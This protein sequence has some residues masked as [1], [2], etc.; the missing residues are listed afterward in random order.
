MISSTGCP[1]ECDSGTILADLFFNIVKIVDPNIPVDTEFAINSIIENAGDVCREIAG[2]SDKKTNILYRETENDPWE[3]AGFDDGSGTIIYDIIVGTKALEPGSTDATEEKYRFSTEGLYRFELA[4][5]TYDVVKEENENN[6]GA[7]P[8]EGSL[9]KSS[10][11][12]NELTVKVY[13][14]Y[15][16][17]KYK[18]IKGEPVI[19]KYLGSISIEDYN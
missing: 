3:K 14:P 18:R 19:V 15:K 11:I 10:K 7:D 2:E 4:A 13:D 12:N 5:D 9:T 16:S 17:G 8:S 6:N 1:V